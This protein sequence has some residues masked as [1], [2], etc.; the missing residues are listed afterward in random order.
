M[1]TGKED[2]QM[3]R[4]EL[5]ERTKERKVKHFSMEGVDL[6]KHEPH[7]AGVNI[8]FQLDGLKV[9]AFK[10]LKSGPYSPFL[11]TRIEKE[12]EVVWEFSDEREDGIK[13]IAFLLS[14]DDGFNLIALI[15]GQNVL[16]VIPLDDLEKCH[17][18][19]TTNGRQIVGGRGLLDTLKLKRQIADSLGFV[20]VPTVTESKL[21]ELRASKAS[22]AA[23]KND[24]V[25]EKERRRQEILGRE[26]IL[27]Y[28]ENGQKIFGIP[29]VEN[30][31]Q[32]LPDGTGVILVSEY[33]SG[34][35]KGISEAFFVDKKGIPKKRS[36]CI[37]TETLPKKS[38]D[39]APV[40]M[41]RQL[42]QFGEIIDEFPLVTGETLEQ[43]RAQKVNSG[44]QFA[45]IYK[46]QPPVLVKLVGNQVETLGNLISL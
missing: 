10:S 38:D 23:E 2:S 31:W 5:K 45:V 6:L 1:D 21:L 3:A 25:A 33:D 42:F 39:V 15:S 11:P 37:V 19:K 22:V 7:S 18:I 40:E 43:L 8:G 28:R 34:N 16:K 27:V 41:T 30:E 29:V 17:V 9:N 13:K 14:H 46:G 20:W 12:Q 36:C 32:C 26:K 35:F 4:I 44:S 24:K